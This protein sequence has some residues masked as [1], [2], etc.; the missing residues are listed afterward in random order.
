MDSVESLSDFTNFDTLNSSSR[1]CTFMYVSFSSVLFLRLGLKFKNST[2]DNYMWLKRLL[3][4]ALGKHIYFYLILSISEISSH[5]R[6]FVLPEWC[7]EM[8]AEQSCLSALSQVIPVLFV[9]GLTIMSASC[10][11]ITHPELSHLQSLLST[12]T[13]Q[14]TQETLGA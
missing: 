10:F 9:R 13:S 6:F 11:I 2:E 12:G 7:S 3:A 14:G 1:R 4:Y 8:C 5:K